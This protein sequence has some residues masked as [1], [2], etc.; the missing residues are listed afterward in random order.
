MDINKNSYVLGF[1]VA[2]TA[3]AST[4]LAV[5]ANALRPAQEAAKLFDRQKNIM[6]AAGVLLE[7]DVRPRKELE[8]LYKVRFAEHVVELATGDLVDQKFTA[9]SLAAVK[10]AK[11]RAKYSV[12]YESKDSAGKTEAWILPV[13]GRGLWSTLYGFLALDASGSNVKG[14]T[15]YEHGETPGLGGEVDNPK[16]KAKWP[17]KSVYDEKGE[18]FGVRV[19]KG[20]VD[21]TVAVEQRHYVDG[22]SGATITCNGVTALIKKDLT[23][24]KP[25][26]DKARSKRG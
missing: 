23:A 26:L 6:M 22:L 5:A 13:S 17:G 15:F 24:Y 3:A 14:L 1:A 19:K 9:A 8:D 11:E 18:L 12:I 7:G 2:V 10:D 25:F 20:Q 4:L 16:W 21:P